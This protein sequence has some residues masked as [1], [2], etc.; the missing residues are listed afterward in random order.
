MSGWEKVVE[1]DGLV[2]AGLTTALAGMVVVFAALAIIAG[3]IWLLPRGLEILARVAPEREEPHALP[4]PAASS[5]SSEDAS[6]AAAIGFAMYQ[7]SRRN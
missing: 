4:Q 3:F 1:S 5:A 2:Y 6:I 7:D